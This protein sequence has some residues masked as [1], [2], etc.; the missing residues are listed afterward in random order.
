VENRNWP[1]EKCDKTTSEFHSCRNGCGNGIISSIQRKKEML[2]DIRFFLRQMVQVG[3]SHHGFK[4]S[5]LLRRPSMAEKVVREYDAKLDS[6]HRCAIHGIP[7]FNRYHIKV[8][9]NGRIEM[10]PR[11]LV[12]PE[13]HSENSIKI[14]NDSMKNQKKSEI[15]TTV[16]IV[17][18][19]E[20]RKDEN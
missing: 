19:Q 1:V 7:A 17:K 13:E 3:I 4:K 20:Y 12:A 6:K 14:N 11:I 5:C 9:K 8:F 16:N 10:T 15:N 18:Y 2:I